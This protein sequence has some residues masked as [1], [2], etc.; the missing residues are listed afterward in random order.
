MHRQYQREDHRVLIAFIIRG[1][2]EVLAHASNAAQPLA[3]RRT[4]TCVIYQSRRLHV[5]HPRDNAMPNKREE[6]LVIDR[7]TRTHGMRNLQ[8]CFIVGTPMERKLR[9]VSNVVLYPEDFQEPK[10]SAWKRLIKGAMHLGSRMLNDHHEADGQLLNLAIGGGQTVSNIM[11]NSLVL[12]NF[13]KL[14]HQENSSMKLIVGELDAFSNP[15]A[16][17]HCQLRALQTAAYLNL[18]QSRSDLIEA[19]CYVNAFERLQQEEQ[20][21]GWYQGQVLVLPNMT[22]REPPYYVLQMASEATQKNVVQSSW[23]GTNNTMATTADGVQQQLLQI[24]ATASD[25]GKVVAVRVLNQGCEARTLRLVLRGGLHGTAPAAATRV[26]GSMLRS[27][28]PPP[29]GGTCIGD[30]P[31]FGLMMREA[32]TPARPQSVVPEQVHAS[33]ASDGSVGV[34]LPHWSFLTLMIQL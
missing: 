8:F 23:T 7:T 25:D 20:G 28:V 29:P 31:A 3:K 4:T 2:R 22:I 12:A 30:E 9:F 5:S 18:Y 15:G 21:S 19:I 33:I 24:F 14:L 1:H 16:C 6:L 34:A 11:K 27:R 17:D 10:L 13:S 26:N 32:N